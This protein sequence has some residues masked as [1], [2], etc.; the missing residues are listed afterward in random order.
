MLDTKAGS[1]GYRGRGGMHR[2]VPRER[3]MRPVT[4]ISSLLCLALAASCS[5]APEPHPLAPP[6]PLSTSGRYIVDAEGARVKLASI[7]WYGASDA[8]H[9]VGGLDTAP[10]DE[11][12]RSI[13]ALG[14]NSVRLPFSNEMLH[15][16][17]AVDPAHI[18][19]N[20][21]LEGKSPLEIFDATIE[22]LAR[23]GILIILN[24]H[25]TRGM[26]CCF[27]DSDGLWFTEEVSES[28]WIED[29]RM[30]VRR[31]RDEPYVV[32]ADLRNEVRINSLLLEPHWALEGADPALDWRAAAE[33]AGE[34]IL[35]ENPDLLIVVEGIN[36]PR[37][38]L[39]RVAE[40]P[41]RLSIPNRLV[42]A[43]HNY[44]FIGPSAV[45]ETYGE[46][47]WPTF[48]ATMD[49]EWGFVA[50]EGHPYT[51]PVW[52]SEFGIGYGSEDDPWFRNIMRYLE[53][54]DFDFAYWPLNPGPKASGDDEPYGLLELDW[55]TPREDFRTEALRK[56]ARPKRG[57]GI[58][59]P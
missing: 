34:A 40:A 12:V 16:E 36:F 41:I 59:A 17:E 1:A 10:I 24:N 22:A 30:I 5:S 31:Y 8:F 46:M 43:A 18:A 11:I 58:A 9:I 32:G 50:E 20:P 54:G 4:L 42:Y 29:W 48:S 53:E 26:W 56:I 35:E 52:L 7:N 21:Q 49:E 39:S 28:R 27:L 57:P 38:H 2:L 3:S 51:A 55:T 25:T 14:L 45:G 23:E 44:G 6:T 37:V 13:R 33:R 19:A 15:I 47:D